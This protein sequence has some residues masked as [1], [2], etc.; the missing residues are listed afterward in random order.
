MFNLK[1]IYLL[2]FQSV[3][4]QMCTEVLLHLRHC[5]ATYVEIAHR[6]PDA[7]LPLLP[8]RRLQHY[9]GLH[10]SPQWL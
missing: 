7:T 10:P 6:P 3:L 4:L 9:V 2:D 8:L 1:I 5:E